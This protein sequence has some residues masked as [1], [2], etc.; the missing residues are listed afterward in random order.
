[1]PIFHNVEQGSGEWQ[2]LRLGIPT[3]SNFAKILTPKTRKFS[4]QARGY[5]FSLVAEELLN[6]SLDSID[7]LEWVA[8]GKEL[9]PTAVR[10]Y[11]FEQEVE[12]TPCG[13]I[14]DDAMTM[15]AT[16]DRLI[17]GKAAALE[18]KCPKPNTHLEYMIDGFGADYLPQAMGQILIG[19]F[20]WVDRYSF[21][22]EMPPVPARTYR[23]EAY[24]ADLKAALDQ[25]NDMKA[26]IMEKVKA[27][28]F[29]LKPKRMTTQVDKEMDW[30]EHDPF[31]L[32]ALPDRGN[33]APDAPGS[34]ADT[35]PDRSPSASDTVARL[36][37]ERDA[38]M[39]EHDGEAG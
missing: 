37:A 25:F 13:L 36:H 38:A 6:Q 16:P 33:G 17:V 4:T 32:P 10:F 14:T 7:Y 9:E 26:E 29:Y 3:A 15:G 8:R 11:E 1:M 12:T 31:G 39:R 18:V 5:I 30:N 35:S 27:R 20:E 19:E 24:L 23:D 21:H 28:G 22:P 2:R 34:D